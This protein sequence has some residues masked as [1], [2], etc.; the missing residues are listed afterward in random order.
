MMK[1]FIAFAITLLTMS[2]LALCGDFSVNLSISYNY[3]TSDFFGESQQSYFI[4]GDNYLETIDNRMGIG[5]NVSINIPLVKRFYLVP[6]FSLNFGHQQY[7]FTNQDDPEANS[8]N[9]TSYFYIYSPEISLLY[10]LFD[11]KNGWKLDLLL[12]LTYSTFRADAEM[13]EEDTNFW[14]LQ[15]GIGA[16]FLDLKRFGLQIFGFYKMPFQ[17]DLYAY[18]GSMAGVSYRF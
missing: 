18:V 14:G 8:Q 13:R 9:E 11:L 2:G 17:S 5:F 4:G 12:G 3:G 1:K 16:R 6:G 7:T 15:L 10:D